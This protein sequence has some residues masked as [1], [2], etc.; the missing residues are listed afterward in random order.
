M[1]SQE[2]IHLVGELVWASSEVTKATNSYRGTKGH[3][4]RERRAA[5][6]LLAALLGRKPTEAEVHATVNI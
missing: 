4:A 2:A 3:E 5:K 1:T 6:A